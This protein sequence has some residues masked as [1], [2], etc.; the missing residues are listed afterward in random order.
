[1]EVFADAL[2]KEGLSPRL[3]GNH[4]HR[5]RER[6]RHGSIPALTGKPAAELATVQAFRV[7]PA[8][9]GKPGR[10]KIYCRVGEVYPRA[11]GETGIRAPRRWPGAGLSPRLRGNLELRPGQGLRP[12]SIPALTG[13]PRI[14]KRCAP[15][16]RVYPRAYGETPQAQP[17]QSEFVGLSPR[18]RGNRRWRNEHGV[19]VGS[20]PALTGETRESC[21]TA[22]L[23]GGLS[24]RLRG[25]RNGT[26]K[27]TEVLRS[28][29]ALTG[30]PPRFSGDLPLSGVYPRAYGETHLADRSYAADGGL[31][32][33]LRGNLDRSP[34]DAQQQGSIP[35]LTGKPAPSPA[36]SRRPRVYPR[37][38][39]ETGEV[40]A[41]GFGDD[42]LSP[43][44]RGNHRAAFPPQPP[45]RSIPALTGKPG[46]VGTRGGSGRVYP[47]AYGETDDG[48]LAD[49][50][51]V[52]LSPRLRG[53]HR[54]G[55]YARGV[56]RSIPALTGKPQVRIH[57]LK[58]RKVYPRAYGETDG[59]IHTGA[60]P[61][62]LSPRLRGNLPARYRASRFSGSIPAL[63]G[64]PPPALRRRAASG[65]Y[66]RAYGE[67]SAK[68]VCSCLTEGLSPRLRGNLGQVGLQLPDRGSIPALTGKPGDTL[69]IL[70]TMRVYPRA[71]G[72]TPT[73]PSPPSG[74]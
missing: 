40:L 28:I 65:V 33:R 61:Q 37:A 15:S 32:P 58:L 9:T 72:E 12:G 63:T 35:A 29:P 69:S 11:Y 54:A 71:Y 2:D 67:T 3:R 44:L 52:G 60:P 30:K 17:V 73:S 38:Y 59:A 51:A 62:G 27:R 26:S 8:L 70:P 48:L 74:T 34:A 19:W 22:C 1:M 43:R 55:S 10:V 5:Q 45:C 46:G 66:P 64:K 23:T 14:R 13:K 56:A 16:G 25:N 68:S 36:R 41:S 53:N 21:T 49:Y 4:R 31:S 20:I 6:A 42:G 7:Y 47:R 50:A 39:G 18:L 24:P 57:D